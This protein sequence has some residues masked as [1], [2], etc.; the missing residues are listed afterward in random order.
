[1]TVKVCAKCIYTTINI[2]II[3]LRKENEKKTVCSNSAV[4]HAAVFEPQNFLPIYN[5]N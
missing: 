5:Y 3:L 2:N 4:L 1:M